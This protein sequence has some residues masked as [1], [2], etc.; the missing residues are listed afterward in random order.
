MLAILILAGLSSCSKSSD[1][2]DDP[3]GGNNNEC[4]SETPK[5]STTISGIISSNCTGSGCHGAGSVNG[6][7]PLTTYEQIFAARSLIRTAVVNKTMPKT[8]SLTAQQIQ[9]ISCWVQAGAPN[10]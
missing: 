3:P 1:G 6:P 2:P 9:A 4:P 5:F 7:G 10:N 8:G